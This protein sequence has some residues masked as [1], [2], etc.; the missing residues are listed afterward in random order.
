MGSQKQFLLYK[1]VLYQKSVDFA[2]LLTLVWSVSRIRTH[3]RVLPRTPFP[4]RRTR[5]RIIILW[6]KEH[7]SKEDGEVRASL[8]VTKKPVS[9]QENMCKDNNLV[10]MEHAYKEDGEVGASS[11]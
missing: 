10:A 11:R 7:S 9:S 1:H 3:F 6:Q 2:K 5:A 4:Q 8:R